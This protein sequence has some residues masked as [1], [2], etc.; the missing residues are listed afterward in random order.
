MEDWVGLWAQSTGCKIFKLVLKFKKRVFEVVE[1]IFKKNAR[2]TWI[3]W[4][5]TVRIAR[6]GRAISAGSKE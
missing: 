6:K 2:I 5:F 4:A 3:K 1:W